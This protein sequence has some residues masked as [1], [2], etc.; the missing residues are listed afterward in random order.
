MR[1][2]VRSDG[3]TSLESSRLGHLKQVVSLYFFVPGKQVA[4]NFHQLKNP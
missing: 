1:G 2:L 3:K 4:I